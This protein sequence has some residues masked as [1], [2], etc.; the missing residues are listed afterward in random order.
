[1]IKLNLNENELTDT[2]KIIPHHIDNGCST[3]KLDK[4]FSDFAIKGGWSLNL[5]DDYIYED[6]SAFEFKDDIYGGSGQTQFTGKGVLSF[7]DKR[8]ITFYW[9][10]WFDLEGSKTD[11]HIIYLIPNQP[12]LETELSEIKSDFSEAECE[13]II[14][15]HCE[16]IENLISKSILANADLFGYSVQDIYKRDLNR[17][18]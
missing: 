4:G 5:A 6:D 2:N 16:R 10:I 13:D 15:K 12:E 1:M 14:D 8:K 18:Y 7:Y 3:I 17:I 9:S 11:E